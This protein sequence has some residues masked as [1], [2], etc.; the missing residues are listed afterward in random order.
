MERGGCSPMMAEG[1]WK[2]WGGSPM[3]VRLDVFVAKSA[4][5]FR[6]KE[7]NTNSSAAPPMTTRDTVSTSRYICL[8]S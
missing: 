7:T 1:Q 6:R 4:I 3:M 8:S 2:G 5:S